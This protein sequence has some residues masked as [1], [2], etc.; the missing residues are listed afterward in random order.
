M[1]VNGIFR[2]NIN[3]KHN[4]INIIY[5]YMTTKDAN[6][7]LLKG[8]KEKKRKPSWLARYNRKKLVSKIAAAL[9]EEK[10]LKAY[11]HGEFVSAAEKKPQTIVI[12]AEFPSNSQEGIANS[13]DGKMDTVFTK[14]KINIIDIKSLLPAIKE[15]IFKE[16]V[17]IV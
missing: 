1:L 17:Q 6:K 11:A 14:Y 3:S 2:Q 8:L 13:V 15:S 9:K 10:V 16:L 5:I 4:N 7:Q 12:Y